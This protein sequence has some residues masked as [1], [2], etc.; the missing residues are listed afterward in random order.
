MGC[1]I[2]LEIEALM[3]GCWVACDSDIESYG[4]GYSVFAFLAGVR[5]NFVIQL[6]SALRS[7]TEHVIAPLRRFI[8]RLGAFDI[9]PLVAIV[10]LFALQS[11]IRSL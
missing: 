10:L 5:N 9:T 2:H 1:D 11:L 6:D 8:P 4:M 7:I 3:H